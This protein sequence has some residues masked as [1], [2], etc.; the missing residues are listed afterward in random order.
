MKNSSG[1]EYIELQKANSATLEEMRKLADE[2][3]AL[4]RNIAIENAKIETEANKASSEKTKENAKEKKDDANKE[5][6]EAVAE[7]ERLAEIET[8]V[9]KTEVLSQSEE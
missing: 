9:A 1:D 5:F 7:A 3:L 4:Q 8:P 2:R 6:E